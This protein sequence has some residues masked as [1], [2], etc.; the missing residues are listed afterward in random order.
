MEG[1]CGAGSPFGYE[2]RKGVMDLGLNKRVAIVTGSSQGI[3]R[4]AALSFAAEG[5]RV[6]VTY[7]RERG[8]AEAVVR[9]IAAEGG[10]ALSRPLDLTR[11]ET[12]GEVAQA[13]LERWG[14]IDVLVNNAVTYPKHHSWEAPPFEELVDADWL[15]YFRAN[16]EG[17]VAAIQ[18]VLPSMRERGWGRIVN[19]SSGVAEDGLPGLSSYGAAKASLHGLTRTLCRELGPAGILVNV[20]MP[21]PTLTERMSARLPPQARRLREQRYPIRRLLP[22]EEVVP[23]IVFLCSGANT[24][25]TGEMIRASGGRP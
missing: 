3:G 25:V 19:V 15:A 22:P 8:R 9:Q 21:G 2:E 12:V 4:A 7:Y 14:R 5:A 23:T 24:A 10:E 16:V 6:A 17:H 20:V 13:V 18:A 1:L 11:P